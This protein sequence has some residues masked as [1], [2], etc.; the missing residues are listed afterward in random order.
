MIAML[1]TPCCA[2]LGHVADD[3]VDDRLH[4]RAVI[5]DEHDDGAVRA[6]HRFERVAPAVGAGEVEGGGVPAELA[7]GRVR[8]TMVSSWRRKWGASTDAV[9]IASAGATI[10][11]IH[12]R[13]CRRLDH[14][15]HAP[16][17]SRR[18]SRRGRA[19]ARRGEASASFF[20]AARTAMKRTPPRRT[21][22]SI[23]RRAPSGGVRGGDAARRGPV[24]I[25]AERRRRQPR[26]S[27]PTSRPSGRRCKASMG[28]PAACEAFVRQMER[29]SR[30]ARRLRVRLRQ[31]MLTAVNDVPAR[32]GTVRVATTPTRTGSSMRQ[33]AFIDE[34]GIPDPPE[35]AARDHA[36]AH[37]A[38]RF[39]D[40]GR[41][42]PV[43]YAGYNDAA[44]GI[45]AHR[46]RVHAAR[47]RGHG[48][49]TALVAALS[50]ELMGAGKRKLFLT[51]DVANPTSNAIYARIG[52]RPENDDCGFDF[53]APRA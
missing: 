48:Y 22:A 42:R 3:L 47:L 26:R 34:V 33:I 6:A 38:R 30:R 7:G 28:A 39:P 51:T 35:R 32:R 19:D 1:P 8:L 17:R 44:P 16:L 31:H 10:A 25:G 21:S 12:R 15:R 37:R 53:I 45:R 27:P 40:L 41:R 24:L 2:Q 23:S 9:E 43:A 14:A 13:T 11:G 46:A 18:L 20:A 50:R 49:A 5:A 29:S 52:F 4:V 36:A